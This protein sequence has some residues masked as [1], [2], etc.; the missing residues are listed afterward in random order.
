MIEKSFININ[1]HILYLLVLQILIWKFLNQF[2]EVY[3]ISYNHADQ[4]GTIT[5]V[6]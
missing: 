5:D 6:L 3:T 4:A 1:V 2:K